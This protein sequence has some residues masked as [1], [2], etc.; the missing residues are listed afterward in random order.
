MFIFCIE[1]PLFYHANTH[2]FPLELYCCKQDVE[3]N[4]L[5]KVVT[6]DYVVPILAPLLKAVHDQGDH[7][8]QCELGQFDPLEPILSLGEEAVCLRVPLD[9][10]G[11][12]HLVAVQ[13]DI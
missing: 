6:K 7:G 3:A 9:V 5:H 2:V 11:R 12:S 10:L 13:G 4:F 1:I 8:V